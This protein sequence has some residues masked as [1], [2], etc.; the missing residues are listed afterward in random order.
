MKFQL[1]LMCFITLV[2]KVVF[3]QHN[4]ELFN[5]GAL[6]HLQ[7]GAEV[8]VLGDVH[9]RGVTGRIENNGLLVV[10][11]HLYGDNLF[12]QRG[13]GT[14]RLRNNLVNTTESQM[15][16]GSFA[17]RGTSQSQIGVN[18]GSFYN[19]E[20]SNSTGIVWL[21]PNAIAGSTP[22]V[23][24]VRNAVDFS[25]VGS[26][27]VNRIITANPTTLPGN[28]DAYPAVFGLL[29]PNPGLG[30]VVDNTIT[31]N[32]NISSID[33]GYVQGKFRRA[34][35]A[36]G[37][38]YGFVVGLEPAGPTAQRG[39]QYLQTNFASNNYDILE[40]YFHSALSN[41]MPIQV[42]CSGYSINY[43][44]GTDH[45]QWVLT[46]PAA[47]AG[48]Y[49]ITVWPQD[50][51]FPSKT[52][53]V[54]TKDN[55]IQGTADECGPSPIG[56]SRGGFNGF[57]ASTF[58]VAAAE[59]LA[60]PSE[61]IQIWSE[62]LDNFIRV[63]WLVASEHNVSHYNLERS[64]D[65]INFEQIGTVSAFGNSSSPLNYMYDDYD[66]LRDHLYYYRYRVFDFDGSSDYSPIVTGELISQTSDNL[67]ESVYLFP[68]P[69][70]EIVNIGI[71][72]TKNRSL[73]INLYNAM[74]QL[75]L[76]N[77]VVAES[78]NFVYPVN[79]N[80]YA[81]GMYQLKITDEL[82]QEVVWQKFIKQ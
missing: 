68:N 57:T 42:E 28:G 71:A 13:T 6:I 19:L 21:E 14:T 44:G 69:A 58:D 47:G 43:W 29:N 60:L 79:V 52:V 23:A 5:N 37:G 16:T 66:V 51:N 59:N 48:T 40:S 25:G 73:T 41:A 63:N 55:A 46:N 56:L 54:V 1:F 36:A 2:N 38:I 50:H 76:S 12:Q 82:S 26:P 11:G 61:L 31:T 7:A 49:S 62:S 22:Y 75:I 18:D 8:H 65:G 15:I 30:A 32:G 20:L 45:G 39:V 81:S 80:H 77:D 4:F 70:T 35:S 17:I 9:M 27:V 10:Q 53:W 67:S 24:D 33:V 34:I 64:A 74:G 78:G 72:S 3:A